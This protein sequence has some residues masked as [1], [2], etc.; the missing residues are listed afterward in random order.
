MFK[1]FGN[2]IN[3]NINE[4]SYQILKNKAM[5]RAET[6]FGK[7]VE[8][9]NSRILRIEGQNPCVAIFFYNENS[10]KYFAYEYAN[11]IIDYEFNVYQPEKLEPV[12]YEVQQIDSTD[13]TVTLNKKNMQTGAQTTVAIQ[14]SIVN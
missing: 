3:D 12:L 1:Q 14:K 6:R 11:F 2:N 4:N 8:H 5:N 7:G 9:I 10:D 13:E